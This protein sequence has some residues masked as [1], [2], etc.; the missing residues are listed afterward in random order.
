MRRRSDNG[1]VAG[2]SRD[3]PGIF[4]RSSVAV[5]G[6]GPAGVSASRALAA[7][8]HRV[9]LV[10]QRR[11]RG[12]IEGV[13]ERAAEAL[14]SAGCEEALARL[15]PALPRVSTWDRR[16]VPSGAEHLVD[17]RRFDEALRR[18]AAR[19][20]VACV[21]GSCDGWREGEH[22]CRLF[23]R[24]RAGE[25]LAGEV[26]FVVDAR[27]RAAPVDRASSV[28]GAPTTALSRSWRAPAALRG[29]ALA[30][31][32][33]GW[34]WLAAPSRGA[35]SLQLFVASE[36]ID[37]SRRH[38]KEIYE[39]LVHEVPEARGWLDGASPRSAVR[40]RDATPVL[41]GG[42]ASPRSLRIGD[43]AFAVDPLS[44]Q[45]IFEAVASAL[46][47][48]PVVNTLLR[49]AA[50]RRLAEEFHRQRIEDAFLR[51]ARAG[52]DAYR[53]ETRWSDE[54]FWIARRAWP[55]DEP[56]RRTSGPA[57]IR[58]VAV[59]ED[60]YIVSRRALV[61][62]DHP[63]GVWRVEGVELVPLLEFAAAHRRER[64]EDLVAGYAPRSAAP[65]SA[66]ERALEWLRLRGLVES[67][68]FPSNEP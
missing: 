32:A 39:A 58:S 26:A 2:K 62:P 7:L 28:R 9:V 49:R 45:G 33:H 29:S 19:A 53:A 60:G 67:D 56:A 46:A 40:A 68:S 21:E 59:S 34:C 42:A 8:G 30:S 4:E 35:T 10:H 63:R 47:A 37:P 1:P 24:P 15:G 48:A 65:S 25:A 20:G 61:T 52:R 43:A 12:G 18:D 6:A 50:D 14:R 31:F 16:S 44:G 27:G 36:S 22:G 3:V 57:T 51:L 17:R 13:S 11:R 23:L 38:I 54:V 41:A 55:D 64:V 66:I 5:V